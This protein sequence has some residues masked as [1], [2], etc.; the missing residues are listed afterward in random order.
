MVAAP[1]LASVT[2]PDAVQEE[3][4]PTGA[5]FW[6][7]V[8]RSCPWP[9]EPSAWQVLDEPCLAVLNRR[10]LDEQWRHALGTPLK[11]RGTVVAALDNPECHV[12]I[13]ES[14]PELYA[15]CAA[16][17]MVRLALLQRKCVRTLRRD[18]ERIYRS[19]T[20]R[21][22][23][24]IASQEEYYRWLEKEAA[25]AA[26]TLWEVYTCR[27]VP[28]EA[29]EWIGALPEPR[30]DPTSPDLRRRRI[31]HTQQE[32]LYAAARRLGATVPGWVPDSRES[33]QDR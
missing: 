3:P 27:T 31:P 29:F 19:R 23:S 25:G 11:T 32:D 15:A 13:G 16:E 4:E 30:G 18:W 10:W 1:P 22:L 7:A 14:R 28:P 20:D 8:R 2:A 12:P 21:A 17:A 5:G 6:A 26:R 9:P 24:R 33:R